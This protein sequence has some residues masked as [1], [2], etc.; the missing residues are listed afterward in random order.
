MFLFEKKSQYIAIKTT[1]VTNLIFGYKGD[2]NSFVIT[3]Q[4]L[5]HPQ[6]FGDISMS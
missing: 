6:C 2:V 1:T 5:T 4:K 3:H